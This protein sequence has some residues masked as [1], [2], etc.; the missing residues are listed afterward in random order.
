MNSEVKV[1]PLMNEIPYGYY[2]PKKTLSQKAREALADPARRGLILLGMGAG[3]AI[4]LYLLCSD[5]F[6]A[7]LTADRSVYRRYRQDEAFSLLT[8]TAFT[9]FCMALPFSAVYAALRRIGPAR[10]TIGFGK[11]AGRL[12]LLLP[13]G[14]AVCLIG[15]LL[16]SWLVSFASACG[17]TFQSY[18]YALEQQQNAPDSFWLMALTA[19]HTAVLPALLEELVFR[20]FIMQPLR[21]YG[22]WFAVVTSALIFGLVHGNM[23]QAPFAVL[24]GIALGYINVVTG[25]MWSNILLHF[26][27]NIFSV[28]SS[29]AV[30]AAGGAGLLVSA[31]VMYGMIAVGV[32]ALIGYTRCNRDFARLRP[33]PYSYLPRKA[34]LFWLTP[35]MLLSLLL[36]AVKI[37]QDIVAR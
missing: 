24:A 2:P 30:T 6:S 31:A 8:E 7:I 33:G 37:A 10:A 13:A 9:M 22:D 18:Q 4:L 27:N 23:T 36:L 28:L 32:A 25:S 3:A 16:S 26:L 11:P 17:L 34:A 20:G 35:T 19:V 1:T 14:L 15:S 5:L 12:S 21:R 29:F